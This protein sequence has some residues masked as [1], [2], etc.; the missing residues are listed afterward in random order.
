[1]FSIHVYTSVHYLY[2]TL[3]ENR[4]IKTQSVQHLWILH[5]MLMKDVL[6]VWLH[7]KKLHLS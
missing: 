4:E 3:N 1:M 2:H 6:A 5:I 7:V